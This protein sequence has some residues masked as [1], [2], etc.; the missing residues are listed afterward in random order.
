MF[1]KDVIGWSQFND[2]VG[3]PTVKAV[4]TGDLSKLF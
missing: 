4:E 3:L 2:I 1:E